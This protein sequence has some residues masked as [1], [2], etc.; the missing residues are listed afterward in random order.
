MNNIIIEYSIK[1]HIEFK[2]DLSEK[3]ELV[4]YI[5]FEDMSNKEFKTAFSAILRELIEAEHE[6]EKRENV[7][8]ALNLIK[9]TVF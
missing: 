1:E 7:I 4:K 2:M 6:F 3:L 9:K 5:L 8:K